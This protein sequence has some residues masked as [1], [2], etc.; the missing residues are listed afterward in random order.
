MK[1][2]MI[3]FIIA[4]SIIL[5]FCSCGS[6]GAEKS[7]IMAATET[8][9]I[10]K[11]ELVTEQMETPAKSENLTQSD[12]NQKTDELPDTEEVIKV[13]DLDIYGTIEEVRQEFLEEESGEVSYYYEMEKFY[14]NDTFPNSAVINGTL[15][16]IYDKYEA[17]YV[18]TA[19]VYGDALYENANI[20]YQF[21]HLINIYYVGEDYIS[22]LYNDVSYMGGA[23]PYSM[24][25]GITIDCKTGNQ[26]F[27]SRLLDKSEDAILAD[28]SEKMGLDVVGTWDDIDFYITDDTIVFFY[29]IPNFWDDV[30]LPRK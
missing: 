7:G 12:Y 27:A 14:L 24:F 25:D 17:Q 16:Q 30:I 22:I 13:Y 20:P 29:R 21:L 1:K 3:A 28:I 8:E 4:Q 15:R 26:I 9:D 23:H 5:A 6:H 11:S 18:D 2:K 10:Q 19:E